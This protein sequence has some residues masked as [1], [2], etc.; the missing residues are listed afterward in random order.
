[1]LAVVHVHGMHGVA[2]A[3]QDSG[4]KLCAA[5]IK[6]HCE[7]RGQSCQLVLCSRWALQQ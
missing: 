2:V 4:C 1:M 6:T 5:E 7:E 3:V